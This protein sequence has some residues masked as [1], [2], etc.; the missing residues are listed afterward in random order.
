MKAKERL[1][2]GEAIRKKCLECSGYDNKEV[3]NCPFVK[4]PLW[5]YR[6]G[7]EEEQNI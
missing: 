1:T 7:R 6:R 3:K 5:R 4:C 2:R